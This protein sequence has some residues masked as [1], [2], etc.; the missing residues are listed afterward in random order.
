M[1]SIVK[2]DVDGSPRYD[3]RYRDPDGKQRKKTFKRRQDAKTFAATTETD[4]LRGTY[5]DQSTAKTTF[6]EH[7]EHWLRTRDYDTRS[8]KSQQ[9]LLENHVYPVI[10]DVPLRAL[11]PSHISGW[12]TGLRNQKNDKPLAKSTRDNLFR[13]VSAILSG[14]VSDE[15]IGRNVAR[16]SSVSRP[17]PAKHDITP[18]EPETVAAVSSA[19]EDRYRILVILGVGLGLRQGEL[20]GLSVDDVDFLRGTVS[21]ERQVKVC[22]PGNKLVFDLPK[23]EKTRKVPLPEGVRDELAAYL[24]RFPG[25]YV[26]LPWDD[27]DGSTTQRHKLIITSRERKALNSAYTNKAKWKPALAAAG[28]DPEDR[29]NMMHVLRHTYASMLLDAGE[30][31]LAVAQNLGHADPAFTLRTYTHLMSRHDERTKAAAD[32]FLKRMSA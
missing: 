20:F 5:L 10:G 8:R 30:S 25:R 32:A 15:L 11:K 14:A 24:A 4:M 17:R 31:I 19:L 27:P 22:Q 26:E 16:A 29:F 9:K 18:W 2:R 3:V 28:L 6:K 12:L 23:Y 21:V 7:A 1:A 13:I